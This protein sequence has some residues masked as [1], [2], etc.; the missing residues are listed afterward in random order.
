MVKKKTLPDS[1]APPSGH[2]LSFSLSFS[3]SPSQTWPY[4]GWSHVSSLSDA[5]HPEGIP[6]DLAE[7]GPG[8]YVFETI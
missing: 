6:L 3:L 8:N 1:A 2:C 7:A 5:V 4:Q